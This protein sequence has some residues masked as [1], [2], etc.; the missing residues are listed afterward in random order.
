V[1]RSTVYHYPQA[2]RLVTEAIKHKAFRSLRS[3]FSAQHTLGAST[4]SRMRPSG[5]RWYKENAVH[6][7][8]DNLRPI[9]GSQFY[10]GKLW[11]DNTKTEY[12]ELCCAVREK[13]KQ[14]AAK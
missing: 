8:P 2:T 7:N 12:S 5:L 4:S 13:A 14:A 1:A 11:E 3:T 9:A 10:I 6:Y